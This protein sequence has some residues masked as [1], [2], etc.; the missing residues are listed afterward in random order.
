MTPLPTPPRPSPTA[1]A[2]PRRGWLVGA[3]F[4]AALSLAGCDDVTGLASRAGAPDELRFSIGGFGTDSRSW[5]VRGDTLVFR[6]RVWDPRETGVDSVRV[7][8]TAEEWR[9]FRSAADG[10]GVSRWKRSYRAQGVVDGTGW[11]LR[12]RDGELRVESEGSN[13]YPNRR[14]DQRELQMTDGFRA[15]LG[16]L[17]A[18]AGGPR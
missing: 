2:V 3:L 5:E 16:A 9:G 18:L 10:A 12:L 6:R 15:F 17:E 8:P 14:G 7:V 1:S 11:G 13:A 4:T